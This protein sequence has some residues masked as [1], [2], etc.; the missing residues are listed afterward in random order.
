MT[1]NEDT[2]VKENEGEALDLSSVKA[3]LDDVEKVDADAPITYTEEELVAMREVKR[4]LVE[5]HDV[6]YVNPRFLAYTVVVSK[7][8]VK[9]ASKKYSQFIKII[10][11]TG[12][13]TVESD[14]DL[15]KDSSVEQFLKDF[16]VPCGKDFNGRQIMWIKGGRSVR[17]D[18]EKTSVRAGILYTLAIHGDNRSFREGITFVIDTSKQGSFKKTGNESKLQKIN[19]SYP[20]RPQAIYLAGSSAPMRIVINGLIKLASFVTKQKILARIKFVTLEEAM[21]KAPKESGPRYLDGGGGN[22]E[23]IF[24]W[25]KKRYHA[26][27]VP[28]L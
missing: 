12:L 5:E 14:E 27:P 4:I 13:D 18:E 1:S 17:V 21:E 16:Y 25:T 8:R 2:N 22:I 26:I 10:G 3:A 11:E 19:Q 23:D 7:G 6:K 15:W 20:L 9:D 28:S 24:E